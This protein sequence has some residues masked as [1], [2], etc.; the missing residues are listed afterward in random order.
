M[1]SRIEEE[2]HGER[3]IFEIFAMAH[4]HKRAFDEVPLRH[5]TS[6][7]TILVRRGERQPKSTLS[8]CVFVKDSAPALQFFM[9]GNHNGNAGR[10]IF[11]HCLYL[12]LLL[13]NS[14]AA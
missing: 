7:R 2:D 4:R 3:V 6:L 13:A 11:R 14:I 10:R 1:S 8:T 12:S 5:R 9:T